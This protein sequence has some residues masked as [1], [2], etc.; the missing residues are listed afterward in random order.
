MEFGAGKLC[1]GLPGA[2]GTPQNVG[3]LSGG[4]NL[5]V[6]SPGHFLQKNFPLAGLYGILYGGEGEYTI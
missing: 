6:G 1:P 3:A 4:Q 2:S 5:R